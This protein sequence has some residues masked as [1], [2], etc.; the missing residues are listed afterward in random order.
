MLFV[1][2]GKAKTGSTVKERVG[3]RGTWKYPS[4]VRVA[5]QYW[6]MTSEP[7]LITVAEADDPASIMMGIAIGITSSN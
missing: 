1:I 6:L 7:T 4:G 5:A 3:R 2:I